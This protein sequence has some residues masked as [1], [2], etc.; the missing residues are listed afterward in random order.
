MLDLKCV[1][2]CSLRLESFELILTFHDHVITVAFPKCES[3]ADFR[4]INRDIHCVM[5]IR[6]DKKGLCCGDGNHGGMAIT[7]TSSTGWEGSHVSLLTAICHI[8][9]RVVEE[10]SA[11]IFIILRRGFPRC[12]TAGALLRYLT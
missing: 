3:I 6:P 9:P 8:S 4:T 10:A 1:G 12:Y 2:I 5:V 7:I 11:S